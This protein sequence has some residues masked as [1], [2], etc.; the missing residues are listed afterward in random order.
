MRNGLLAKPIT[1]NFAFTRLSV[2]R[3]RCGML[4]DNFSM[5]LNGEFGGE[6]DFAEESL[7]MLSGYNM[8]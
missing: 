3:D 8:N 2:N 5:L 1:K 4:V 6:Y 7:V